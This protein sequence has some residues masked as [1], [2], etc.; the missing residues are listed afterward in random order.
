VEAAAAA[1]AAAEAA[2]VAAMVAAAAEAAAVAAM[3]AA[4][5]VGAV[6]LI[7]NALA[8]PLCRNPVVLR[9]VLPEWQR[10]GKKAI[11]RSDSR[12]VREIV[13][14]A[15]PGIPSAAGYSSGI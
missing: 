5:E 13:W 15:R 1:E 14:K 7:R 2:A 10:L 9:E 12:H 3:V 6:A 8:R 4:E 11:H